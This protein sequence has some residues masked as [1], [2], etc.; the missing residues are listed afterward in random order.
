MV[1]FPHV[2]RLKKIII[3]LK[4]LLSNAFNVY[5]MEVLKHFATNTWYSSNIFVDIWCDHD[6]ENYLWRFI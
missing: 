5:N 2:R 1:E 6:T 3:K 4:E